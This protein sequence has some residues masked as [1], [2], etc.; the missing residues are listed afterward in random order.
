MIEG[1]FWVMMLRRGEV[2][3]VVEVAANQ[4]LHVPMI[5]GDFLE[6]AT[7]HEE[8]D[9]ASRARQQ[10]RP[11]IRFVGIRNL[12]FRPQAEKFFRTHS[13]FLLI[14]VDFLLTALLGSLQF[15]FC[16]SQ[17]ARNVCVHRPY[18]L[19]PTLLL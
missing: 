13:E 9:E 3:E 7:L 10:H 19:R 2:V 1:E 5:I 16:K 8:K 12:I 17:I 15:R 4:V 6:V 14:L 11:V 18:L